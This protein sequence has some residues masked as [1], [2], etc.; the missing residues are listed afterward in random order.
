[1]TPAETYPHTFAARLIRW[2]KHHGRHHL[3]WQGTRD[4]YAIWVSEIM[5]QQTQVRTV[6]PYYISFMQRFPDVGSLASAALDDVL[7]H[8]SGLGYYSRGRNLH[9]A[10]RQIVNDHEGIFP[11]TAELISGLP[12]VGRSTAAAIAVFAYGERCAILDGNV[13]RILARYCGMEGYPGEKRNEIRLWLKA[14]ALLPLP[15]KRDESPLEC[16]MEAYTQALMDL[17]STVC[18]RSRPRCGSCPLQVDCIAY[19]NGTIH[20]LPTPRPRKVLPARETVMLVLMKQ[21]TVLLEKRPSTGVWGGLWCLPEMPPA[22]NVI[23]HC[24]Q[25]FGIEATALERM[26]PL[27]HTFTH[28]RM[29]ILPQPVQVEPSSPDTVPAWRTGDK[30]MHTWLT[31]DDALKAAIPAPVRKLLM[32]YPYWQSNPARAITR[33]SMRAVSPIAGIANE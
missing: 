13:K 31:L 8:W 26:P 32:Q 27:D 20:N 25:R 17:G 2:Q 24:A 14:E 5:L 6:I 33:V 3:P 9:R 12:G 11:K 28:F 23:D 7:A 18:T 21:E 4:P 16:G 19:R 1:M 15:S 22:E 29:R 10:A 30:A